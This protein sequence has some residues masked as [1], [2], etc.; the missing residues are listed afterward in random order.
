MAQYILTPFDTLNFENI[1]QVSQVSYH[2]ERVVEIHYDVE[3]MSVVVQNNGAYFYLTSPDTEHITIHQVFLALGYGSDQA[4]VTWSA[5]NEHTD[6]I[7]EP[8][9]TAQ[10]NQI[11]LYP[12][13]HTIPEYHY[14]GPLPMIVGQPSLDDGFSEFQRV[15][16]VYHYDYNSSDDPQ[17]IED[18]SQ[19]TITL[20]PMYEYK[21]DFD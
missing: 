2:D 10:F 18:D 19:S 17:N 21:E 4:V 6:V 11:T 1:I 16:Y 9:A 7:N 12:A 15:N 8:V 13:G 14:A 20:S 5:D 3:T